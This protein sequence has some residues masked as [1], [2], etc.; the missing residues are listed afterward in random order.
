MA[1]SRQLKQQQ[2]RLDKCGTYEQWCAAASDYDRLSGA[3]AWRAKEKT[4]LY[5][6]RQIRR[7]LERLRDYRH[8]GDHQNLLFSLNEGVHG[9][10]GGMG[11]S[12]LHHR[13]L[14][15]TKHLI[16]EYVSEISTSIRTIA[17][18]DAGSVSAAEKQDFF[19]RASLCFG[20]S[21]LMLSGGGSLGHF[22]LGV[23]KAL[24]E[25]G[26]VP[27]VLSGSS[28]GS[29]VSAIYG[30]RSRAQMTEHLAREA[31]QAQ[32][33]AEG[34]Q[35]Q[36]LAKGANY[37]AEQVR[38]TFEGLIPDLTFQ[39]AYDVSGCYINI[40][41]APLEAHQSSRLLNAITAPNVLVRDAVMA[42]CALP[43]VF[44]AVALRAKNASGEYQDYLPGRRWIDGSF[45]EDLPMKRLARL[46]GVNH[47][48][49][50]LINPIVRY[51]SD[52]LRDNKGLSGQLRK[53]TFQG[54]SLYTRNLNM[55]AQRYGK[56]WPKLKLVTSTAH[57]IFS[58]NYDVDVPVYPNFSEFDLKKL[59][60]P[61]GS[62]ELQSLM[63]GGERATW[64]RL[65]MIATCTQISRT[66]DE[67]RHGAPTSTDPAPHRAPLNDLALGTR[68]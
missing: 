60:K 19:Q 66:L 29:V 14:L 43:G 6:Y 17:T 22:H 31:V 28:A 11:K 56:S 67:V 4:H 58:Q 23:V 2:A 38:A 20:R 24:M 54:V 1:Q 40:S 63:R 47:Y 39:E 50:S 68:T 59:L 61:L 12:V 7:R 5:D 41:V 62:T 30:T 65:G 36:G 45:S 48:V 53:L 42:S 35:I 44:P 25:Q 64:R 9:N 49:G 15:G 8:N 16:E 27:P 26:L 33:S 52:E 10:M 34:E 18:L 37:S 51:A 21:A 3:T 55:I 32:F 57:S 46:Y 13:A